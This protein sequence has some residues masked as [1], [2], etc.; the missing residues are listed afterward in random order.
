M[1]A[2]EDQ[3]KFIETVLEKTG[4]SQT[5]LAN[6]A[7]LDPSTLSRFLTKGRNGHALRASTIRRIANAAGI[8]FGSMVP[9]QGMS[10]SEAD[11]Y[12]FGPEDERA[13]RPEPYRNRDYAGVERQHEPSLEIDE[14]ALGFGHELSIEGSYPS[15]RMI[16]EPAEGS[17]PQLQPEQYVE[18]TQ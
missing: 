8:A 3:F 6:R 10:E 2:A 4:W 15:H 12:S 9:S 1:T 18:V 14:P 7:G 17:D 16:E 13:P 11:P 5:D